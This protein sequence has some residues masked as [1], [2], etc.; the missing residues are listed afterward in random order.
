[1]ARRV[2]PYEEQLREFRASCETVR[3]SPD[4]VRALRRSLACTAKE[5]AAALD[6]PADMITAWERGELF[7]TKRHVD[8]M[9]SLSERGPAAIVRTPKRAAPKPPMQVLADPALWRL[10][11]KLLAHAEL[12]QQAEQ[13]AADYADPAD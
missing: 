8:A 1:M 11:R 9:R 3:M 7:P 13:L 10:V 5:L 12:R 2:V 4:D 6:V